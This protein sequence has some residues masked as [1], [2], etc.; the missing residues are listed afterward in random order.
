MS[1]P[2]LIGLAG[3]LIAAAATGM[4]AGRLVR[5]PRIYFIIW[6]AATLAIMVALVAQSIGF[7]SGFSQGS[8]RAVQL[9]AQLLAPLWI[10]WGLIELVSGSEAVRFAARL[11]AGAVTVVASVILATD[12]LTSR[13]FGK[14]WPPASGY[15]QPISIDAIDV[16][17]A[18]AV[19]AALAA[20]T[21]AV[22]GAV[23]G[24]RSRRLVAGVVPVALAVLATVALRFSLPDRAGYPLLSALAAVLVWFGAS[25]VP[26]LPGRASQN[27]DPEADR[28]G[29]QPSRDNG[30]WPDDG[31]GSGDDSKLHDGIHVANGDATAG[32][33]QA[34]DGDVADGQYE[35]YGQRGPLDPAGHRAAWDP[36]VHDPGG[37]D[38]R[39]YLADPLADGA[40]A[41]AGLG[42]GIEGGMLRA[43][44]APAAAG[45][46]GQAA[47]A[48]AG[49]RPYGRILIFTLL[50]DRV[51][52]FDRLAD[53][54]AEAVMVSEPDTLVYVIH[55]VPNAPMQRIFYEIYRD[56]AA[57]DHHENQPYMQRFVTERRSCVLATNVIELRL[58]FAKVAPLPGPQAAAP[59]SAQPP[60]Q[61]PAGVAVP[62]GASP[63]GGPTRPSGPLPRLQ[64]LPPDPH[65]SPQG[66]RGPQGTQ[67]YQP[68][69]PVRAQYP[70]ASPYGDQP[71]YQDSGQYDSGQY[72]SG[73]YPVQAPYPGG[74][75]AGS[76]PYPQQ[77]YP[78]EQPGD[79]PRADQRATNSWRTAQH[80]PDPLR[81]P[82]RQDSLRPDPLRPDPQRIDPL[83][84]D[85]RRTD[86]WRASVPPDDW[87]RGDPLQGDPWRGDPLQ[88]DP[89][90]GDPLQSDPRRT[91]S[92]RA[93]PPPDDPWRGDPLQGDPRR[94]DAWR[95]NPPPDGWRPSD[96]R[97]GEWRMDES[98][99]PGPDQP[100][101]P[102]P[103]Q[104][105]PGQRRTPSAG[106]PNGSG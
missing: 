99:S 72:D 60:V 62:A 7:A 96:R 33:D 93:S 101:Q 86:S 46:A 73:Q 90:R 16:V 84:G 88:G 76:A 24:P 54:A 31:D 56:R 78:G 104:P 68:P 98:W 11:L 85:P 23:K 39:G 28:R 75:Y 58:K 80:R 92:W 19:V 4:L 64:P 87:R 70:A 36:G 103:D 47:G 12:P 69:Q 3:V 83:Q 67:R 63:A 38:G 74:E 94:T 10:G 89:R 26:K 49:A 13:K 65:L 8:F 50:D 53:Q 17:Q 77:R 37:P 34:E 52:D 82:L 42:P 97:T 100:D 27:A 51:D 14:G 79:Q 61:P 18:L 32:G 21:L 6:T 35:L 40:L 29:Q 59:P 105:R 71:P 45:A 43:D 91:D 44:G 2:V 48:G 9:G 5:R 15:F 106:R 95:A 41:A 102:R 55:L 1:L 20:V 81:D 25:R 57:F 30:D 66:P 22:A